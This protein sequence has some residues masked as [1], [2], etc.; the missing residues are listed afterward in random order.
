MKK[1]KLTF[2][3]SSIFLI[4]VANAEIPNDD[5]PSTFLGPTFKGSFTQR[6]SDSAAYSLLGELG[7]RNY[8]AGG[9]LGWKL[10]DNQAFKVS[11]EYLWQRIKYA[12]FAGNEL[13]WMGQ[14]AVGAGYQYNFLN[15]NDVN[16]HMNVYASHAPG[17][18]L[19]TV[20]GT[21]L[22]EMGIIHGFIDKRHIAGSNAYGADP[23]IG[24]KFWKGSQLGLNL[25]YDHVSY[26]MKYSSD[27]LVSGFGGT[28]K[29][30]QNFGD[31][32]NVGL[33]ASIRRPF[34]DYR[35]SITWGNF[36]A[37]GSRWSMGVDGSFTK[38][39]E[40]LPDSYNIALLFNYQMDKTTCP[41]TT[42]KP[43]TYKG[44]FKGEIPAPMAAPV[45]HF[46]DWIATPAV[47]MP[48]VLAIVDEDVTNVCTDVVSTVGSI[49]PQPAT[50]TFS[51][52]GFFSAT[53]TLTYSLSIDPALTGGDSI[54]IDANTGVVT[55]V[56]NGITTYTV[57]ITA[58]N[59]CGSATQTFTVNA[60]GGGP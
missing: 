9:T 5:H 11:A 40:S 2:A 6:V 16:L 31:S 46:M 20:T 37:L 44:G 26:D 32:V 47:Y 25:N 48:Q 24:L 59:L 17:E 12:F 8:R 55:G 50:F 60:G 13:R 23:G 42:A 54:V 22:D 15:K 29:L 28:A 19:D 7:V 4:S 33:S 10:D 39:K 51:A 43:V 34:N 30:S 35:A 38:G 49:D 53:G 3:L 57:T 1:I 52:A 21:Y 58:A 36:A 18:Q 27:E 45:D 14:G 41:A 56:T